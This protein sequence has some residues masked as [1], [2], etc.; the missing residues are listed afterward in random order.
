MSVGREDMTFLQLNYISEIYNCGSINKAA[1]N[2]FVS[3]SSLS[4]SIRELEEELGIKI[5]I[6]SNRGIVLTEDGQEFLTQIR[7]IIEQQKKVEKFYSERDSVECSKLNISAQRYPFCAK[8]FVKLLETEGNE[9]FEFSFKETDMD[10]VIEN[11]SQRK[12]DIGIIF[13]SDMTEKFMNRTL[14]ANDLE[15]K[16][17]S[18]IRPHV[19]LN[20][21]HPLA[22]NDEI[23]LNELT[24]YPYVVFSKKNNTSANFSEEAVFSGSLDFKKIVYIND[25]A[26]AYNILSHTDSFTTGSGLLPEGYSPGNIISI[27]IKDNIDYMRLVW[28]KLKDFN[29]NKRAWE[30]VSILTE[31]LEEKMKV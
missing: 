8:A 15:F 1:Q 24:G 20:K 3:Q 30:F 10:K 5:F 2:L 27:P 16:E 23:A 9:K 14:S 13:L 25:R 31:M 7:P 12:S 4:S 28:I 29:I 21:D 18:R 19:F 22:G 11:V 17:I 6:R 26:T